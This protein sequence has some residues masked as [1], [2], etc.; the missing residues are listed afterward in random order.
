[1]KL[2]LHKSQL[3]IVLFFMFL[4]SYGQE[5]PDFTGDWILNLEKSKLQAYWTSGLTYGNFIID[6][7]EPYFSLW[8]TFTIN[9]K[10]KEMSYKIQ[11]NGQEQKGRLGTL[12]FMNWDQDTLVLVV[13]RK[14][15]VID[16]VRYSL[17]EDR[18][19]FTADERVDTPK[20]AYYNSW[21]FDRR[22]SSRD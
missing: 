6:H 13:K 19:Q 16:S 21:V 18:K 10:E 22:S 5:L 11:T 7:K 15:A 12:W 9:G 2:K 20:S 3:S 8:R 4:V 17:S 14:G 1:M